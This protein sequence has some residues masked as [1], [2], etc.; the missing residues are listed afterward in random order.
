MTKFKFRLKTVLDV[1]ELRK[2]QAVVDYVE[3]LRYLEIQEKMLSDL[4]NKSTEISAIMTDEASAGISAFDIKTHSAFLRRIYKD[5]KN[6]SKVVDEIQKE[7]Q[8]M[9]TA[10]FKLH[11]EVEVLDNLK[12]RQQLAFLTELFKQEEKKTD[13]F[14]TYS[15]MNMKRSSI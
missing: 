12:Q 10:L 5:I 9:Q 1:K 11:N 14:V 15:T 8:N 2:K 6:Q 3:L 13:E 4:I 7:K